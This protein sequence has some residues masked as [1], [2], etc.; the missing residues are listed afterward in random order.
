[1]QSHTHVAVVVASLT[2][3]S[4]PAAADWQYT[5]WGMSVAEVKAS[6]PGIIDAGPTDSGRAIEIIGYP[7]LKGS[8]IAGDRT[9]P[10]YFLFKAGKLRGVT[11]MVS[12][13]DETP[14]LMS[15]RSQ[16][17]RPT[18]DQARPMGACAT[19]HV[20]WIGE[21]RPNDIV[22]SSVNCSDSGRRTARITYMQPQII[23][24]L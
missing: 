17:G 6:A 19:V 18:K 9:F 1:M 8:Y 20:E 7:E 4:L 13:D 5:R 11:L 22:F 16:Y 21:G 15:L 14:A 23:G 3:S 2:A 24:G 12:P 10:S